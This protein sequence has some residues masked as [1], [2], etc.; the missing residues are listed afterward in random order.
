MIPELR[1]R[2]KHD[3]YKSGNKL[4]RTSKPIFYGS[5]KPLASL[6]DVGKLRPRFILN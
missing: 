1:V 4:K 3:F 2:P 6:K 5:W